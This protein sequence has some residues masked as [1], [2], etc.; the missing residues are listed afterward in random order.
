MKNIKQVIL[1]I[2]GVL[3]DSE[4]L[5]RFS[6]NKTSKKFSLDIDFINFKNLIGLSLDSILEKIVPKE[7]NHQKI[8]DYYKKIALKNS[9]LIY[10]FQS[11]EDLLSYLDKK[12]KLAIFTS[13][14]S[15]RLDNIIKSHFNKFKFNQIITSDSLINTKPHPEGLIKIFDKNKLNPEEAVFIGDTI[16]D[17]KAAERAGC[18]FILANWGYGK[19]VPSKN[20]INKPSEIKDF[21]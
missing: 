17:F 7:Y 2:D 11:I 1:D 15:E 12:Y 8:A 6:W 4:N 18:Y 20:I 21:L 19:N 3:I 5:M 16:F 9:H 13:K 14:T 10:P